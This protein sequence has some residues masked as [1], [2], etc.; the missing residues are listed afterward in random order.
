M[1]K[2]YLPPVTERTVVWNLLAYRSTTAA[3]L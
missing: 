1:R 2:E 3:A